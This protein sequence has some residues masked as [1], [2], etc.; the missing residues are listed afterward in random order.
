MVLG[1]DPGLSGGL[2]L[3]DSSTNTCKTIRMPIRKSYGSKSE[4]DPLTINAWLNEHCYEAEACFLER[5]TSR[6]KQGVTS[7]F[8]FG[9]SYGML[10]AVLEMFVP[11]YTVMP[12]AWKKKVLQGY[13]TSD[14]SGAIAFCGDNYP[15]VNLVQPRC[16]KPH[17]GI[18]DAICLAHYGLGA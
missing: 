11:V 9:M 8:N 12:N 14:K 7:S 2:A 16:R 6:P 13:V 15:N 1:V 10:R 18:A 17:D 5:V 3:I 4:V